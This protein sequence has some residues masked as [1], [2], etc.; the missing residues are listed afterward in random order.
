MS[1]RR[2]LLSKYITRLRY[3]PEKIQPHLADLLAEKLVNR[4][5]NDFYNPT[6]LEMATCVLFSIFA[7]TTSK[8]PI[9]ERIRYWFRDLEQIGAESVEGYAMRTDL[10]HVEDTLI[11]KAPRDPVN[12]DILHELFIGLY[13]TNRLRSVLPNFAYIFG[14]FNCSAPIIQPRSEIINGEIIRRDEVEVVSY[15]ETS[16]QDFGQVP[17]VIYENIS[18]AVSLASYVKTCTGKEFF[19]A[20]SQLILSLRRAWLSLGFVHN[21]LHHENVLMRQLDQTFSLPYSTPQGNRYITSDLVT[22]IID[23]GRSRIN[24]KGQSYGFK[25]LESVAVFEEMPLPYLDVYKVFFFCLFTMM[26][27]GNSEA[28]N[29]V[30]QLVPYFYPKLGLN[31]QDLFQLLTEKR[32]DVYYPFI[33]QSNEELQRFLHLYQEY[34]I[35]RS[36]NGNYPQEWIR[37]VGFNYDEFFIY[38]SQHCDCSFLTKEPL[39]TV[40]YCKGDTCGTSK[41]VLNSF[42][43]RPLNQLPTPE[44]FFEFYDL[45]TNMEAT[46][47]FKQYLVEKFKL[48]YPRSRDDY[49]M[50][51]LNQVNTIRDSVTEIEPGLNLK[52]LNLKDIV[53]LAGIY[54]ERFTLIVDTI[55]HWK[56]LPF[57]TQVGEYI[58][59]LY[60][61]EDLHSEINDLVQQNLPYQLRL[62]E[63][64]E[65]LIA[66]RIYLSNLLEGETITGQEGNDPNLTWLRL[67]F[68]NALNILLE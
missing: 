67:V 38:M 23:F 2:D 19:L 60:H 51:L 21:D 40:A 7:A 62:K 44:D 29:Q 25:G 54:R 39:T 34:S 56:H 22:T 45:H 57:M 35:G 48:S 65:G 18:P 46:L 49:L 30:K 8:I 55:S 41:D 17:Y 52:Q 16:N 10:G 20:F 47:R 1:S 27:E 59:D 68:P 9:N 36:I 3:S 11:L 33:F 53:N 50:N 4:V 28:F 32:N 5:R 12:S 63:Y 64:L 58:A 42:F 43:E 6:V 66:D 24:Y 14:G 37:A 15:C 13:G 61:D 31:D 26:Q